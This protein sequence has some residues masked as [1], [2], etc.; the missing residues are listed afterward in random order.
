MS[1][2]THSHHRHT[3]SMLRRLGVGVQ[4]I[5]A[6][7]ALLSPLELAMREATEERDDVTGGT[8]NMCCSMQQIRVRCEMLP[9]C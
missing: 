5:Q 1:N 8:V 2:R 4:I 9:N 7:W 6:S 3:E